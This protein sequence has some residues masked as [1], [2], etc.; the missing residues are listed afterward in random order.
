VGKKL[1][2][3]RE[4]ENPYDKLAIVIKDE[5]GNK[6]GYV[7]RDQN[8]IL[9]RLMDAGKLIY[10]IIYGKN[11]INEWLEITMQIFMDD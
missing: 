10:A 2:F 4:P 5:N 9:S 8:E 6:L 1:Y 3:Y 7:P 11:Y